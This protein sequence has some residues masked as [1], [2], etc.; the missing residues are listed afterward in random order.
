[1]SSGTRPQPETLPV[2]QES[3]RRTASLRVAALSAACLLLVAAVVLSQGQSVVH[4]P[5]AVQSYLKDIYHSVVPLP[6][7]LVVYGY[8]QHSIKLIFDP[9]VYL[10]VLGVLA[11]ERL[12]PAQ[13]N[14]P[15]LSPGMLQDYGWFLAENLMF[16]QVI[17]AY[18]GFLRTVYV[19]HWSFLT[20]PV[21]SWPL[22]ARGLC[23]ILVGDFLSWLHHYLRHK[24]SAFWA[25]HVIHHSQREMNFFTDY[26]VH[27]MDRVISYTIMFLPIF[28][29]AFRFPHDVYLLF[30]FTWYTRIYHSNLRTNFGFFKHVLVT[31]QSHRVH[32]S[33]ERRHWDKNFG[34]I[35]TVWD[36]MF[37]TLY[38]KYDEY[39]PTGVA[40]ELFPWERNV[41]FGG[42]LRHLWSQSVY[43]FQSF[44]RRRLQRNAEWWT[45]EPVAD[46]QAQE[47]GKDA[48]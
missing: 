3:R 2:A 38:K 37:G 33:I 19:A 22:W 21:A 44:G 20:L 1:M 35:F 36:R 40:D 6:V 27:L 4:L 12:I 48:P 32:H 29:F 11:L 25:F 8:V 26:R 14:Q 45:T 28:M 46:G 15:L 24:V 39:P 47:G 13:R 10:L 18:A 9:V 34:V 5:G 43:P 23:T 17:A 7:R 30:L 42:V 41:G 16:L 31:P